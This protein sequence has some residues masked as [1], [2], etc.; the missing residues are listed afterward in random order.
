MDILSSA[1]KIVLLVMVGVLSLLSVISG[2]HDVWVGSF[3]EVTKIILV[4]FTNSL[5][6]VLGFYF[7]YKGETGRVSQVVTTENGKSSVETVNIVPPFV[8]K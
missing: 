3:S 1:S 5:S 7:A 6:M 8:G 4:A 2:V